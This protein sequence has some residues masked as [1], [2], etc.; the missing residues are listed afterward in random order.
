[1][2][3]S[4]CGQKDFCKCTRRDATYGALVVMAMLIIMTLLREAPLIV[5]VADNK[6]ADSFMRHYN[7]DSG[8]NEPG[9]TTPLSTEH[10][11]PVSI[12]EQQSES[13][14]AL[15]E[16][17]DISSIVDTETIP[18]S[19]SNSNYIKKRPLRVFTVATNVS[20]TLFNQFYDSARKQRVHVEVLGEGDTLMYEIPLSAEEKKNPKNKKAFHA[21]ANFGRKLLHLH[22]ACEDLPN[23]DTLV[24]LVDSYDSLFVGA[25]LVSGYERAREMAVSL[26][27]KGE[28]PP[29]IITGGE[30]NCWPDKNMTS[31]YPK[32]SIKQKMRYVNSGVVAGPASAFLRLFK[33]FL[34]TGTES[35]DQRYWAS[36]F[37]Q[38]Q[39][40]DALPVIDVD[41]QG[42]LVATISKSS[43]PLLSFI[44][45]KPK[46]QGIEGKPQILHLPN[47]KDRVAECAKIINN[48][49][50]TQ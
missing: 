11:P 30:L 2:N 40:D 8:F 49:G 44:R 19:M 46:I 50:S 23:K 22:K 5:I 47:N 21:R 38:S 3:L 25:D 13:G 15:S 35:S 27:A 32:Y 18:T 42:H 34:Y 33:N 37:I 29:E 12:G 31:L 45:G 41:Y 7:T 26:V 20:H 14:T 39:L 28:L 43:W 10:G 1:M 6:R 24:V 9:A 4:D 17:S 48:K 36:A 16:L